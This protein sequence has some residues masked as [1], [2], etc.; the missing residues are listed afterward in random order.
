MSAMPGQA[1]D[2]AVIGNCIAGA[3]IDPRGR[4]VWCCWP[5]LDG[6]PIFCRLIDDNN[7]DDGYFEVAI[8]NPVNSTQRY[9]G[10]TAI[11]ETVLTDRDGG[12]TRIIDFMP[13]FKRLG[14]TFRP[15]MVVRI[16]EPIGR[17]KVRVR[18]RPKFNYGATR[19]E[20]VAGSNHVRFGAPGS[21]LRVTT[22]APIA[23]IKSESAFVMDGPLYFILESDGAPAAPLAATIREYL[24][25]TTEYWS[26][27][28]RYLSVPFEWQDAVIRAAITLKLCSF[29]ETGAIVAALTTS[30]P[31]AADTERNWDYRFCWLRDAYF[32]VLVLNRLGVTRTMEDFIRYITNLAALED[33]GA[34]KP[35]Y[36]IAPESSIDERLVNTLSG[37]RG[38]RPVRVGNAASMQVQNDSY[39]SIVLAAT[40]MFFDHRLPRGGD[41]D[42]FHLLERLGETARRVALTPDAGLWEFRGRVRVHT[43]SAVM[44]WAACRRLTK[45]ARRLGLDQRAQYWQKAAEE[46]RQAILDGAWNADQNSFVESFGGDD[47]DASLLLL[48][49][50]GFVAAS[51]P[52]FLGT[53]AR[54]EQRLRRGDHLLRYAMAD[55]FGMPRTSFIICTFW[56]IDALAAVGRREEARALFERVLERR[57]HLGLLSED[58]DVETGQLWGNFPQAYS[59]VG[60]IT[61]AMRLSRGWEEAFWRDS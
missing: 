15:A 11:L 36:P 32:V 46:L 22:N 50:V 58:L 9:L 48:Q 33:G 13:R 44:C 49:E 45:I 55:D 26:E 30:I 21:G 2:L 6:D 60:L 12:Q 3:L 61:S 52:R 20:A 18:M 40:Q 37:F 38:M 31:E 23:F 43:Y 14:R 16:V 1:L 35:V 51:D 59:M 56:Y 5:R 10:N 7:G 53:L 17:P 34:L 25:E 39:G 42:L 4:Y 28:S 19:P 27:W 57:N 41:V 24:D 29:E 54:V 47:V 8:E